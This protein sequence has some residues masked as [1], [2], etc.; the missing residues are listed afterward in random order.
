MLQCI[1]LRKSKKSEKKKTSITF[2]LHHTEWVRSYTS[3][4]LT[5]GSVLRI[6]P[7]YTWICPTHTPVLHMDLSYAYTRPTHGSV[8]RIHP[9]YTWI[10]PTH[11]P[12]LH[13][14]LSYAYTR[15][16]HG[17][18]LRIHPSYTWIRPTNAFALQTHPH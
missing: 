14:D 9:S 4:R 3:T 7:S 2:Y 15:P 8:L 13:M 11:T 17:S 1:E 16:T 12:V 6:H 18:V 10:C 5:D